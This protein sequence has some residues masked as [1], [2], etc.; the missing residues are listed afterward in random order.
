M[1]NELHCNIG[2]YLCI[3]KWNK[4]DLAKN[5]HFIGSKYSTVKTVHT[6]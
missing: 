1:V 3:I 6:E 4:K 2:K 5:L